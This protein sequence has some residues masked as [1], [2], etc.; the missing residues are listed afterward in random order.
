MPV[1]STKYFTVPESGEYATAY[2]LGLPFTYTGVTDTSFIGCDLSSSGYDPIQAIEGISVYSELESSTTIYDGDGLLNSLGDRIYK[3]VKVE[4]S[5]MFIQGDLDY[6]AKAWLS[7]FYKDHSKISVDIM[8]TPFL[9]I[10]DTVALTDEAN[11]K[12]SVR[13]FVEGLQNN[14]GMYS[15][16]LGRY[17]ES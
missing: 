10:G 8:Y 9:N 14:N 4:E 13:Y 17:P 3:D 2:I 15:L 6:L 16:S 7:E 12:Y 5:P 11:N 1:E